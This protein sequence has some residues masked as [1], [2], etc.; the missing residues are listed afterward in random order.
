MAIV[1]Q[2]S[3]PWSHFWKLSP[4][5]SKLDRIKKRRSGG[6]KNKTNNNTSCY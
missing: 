5:L 6:N 1:P 2:P 3:M 4:D